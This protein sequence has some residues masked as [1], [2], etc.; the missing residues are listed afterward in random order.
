MSCFAETR[1]LQALWLEAWSLF[2]L[3][4]TTETETARMQAHAAYAHEQAMAL[5]LAQMKR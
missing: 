2:V 3:N 5:G 4:P 1:R